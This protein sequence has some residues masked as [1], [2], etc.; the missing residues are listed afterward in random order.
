MA[1]L[2]SPPTTP[3]TARPATRRSLRRA[4]ASTSAMARFETE[5]TYIMIKPDGVQRGAVGNIVSRFESKG[6]VLK[7]LKLFSCPKSL[8][9]EH[10]KARGAG[11]CACHASRASRS[12]VART[13]PAS[14]SSRTSSL[15]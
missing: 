9:E 2:M 8:A 13:W 14:R 5:R 3:F 15:T 7:A 12:P 10:Y 1:S 11:C 6:F 4:A